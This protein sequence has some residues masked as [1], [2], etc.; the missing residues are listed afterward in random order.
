MR[1][2][3]ACKYLYFILLSQAPERREERLCKAASEMTQRSSLP[4]FAAL[5]LPLLLCGLGRVTCF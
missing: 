3:G 1:L 4:V 5:L 2:D